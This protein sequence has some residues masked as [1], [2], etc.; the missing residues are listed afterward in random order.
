MPIPS[1]SVL[2]LDVIPLFGQPEYSS[3]ALP[4]LIV[5][6]YIVN[7][8]TQNHGICYAHGVQKGG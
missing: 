2:E 6:Y 1:V 3:A 5:I 7:R 8:F 4:S